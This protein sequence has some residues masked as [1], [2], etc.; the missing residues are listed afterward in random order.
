MPV[1]DNVPLMA[2]YPHPEQKMEALLKDL[3]FESVLDVGAG[4]G[5]VFHSDFWNKPEIVRK[6][7][8][9][10]FW[11]RELP[12][13]WTSLLGVDVCKLDEHYAPNSFDCVLCC[14]VLEHVA[15]SKRALEQ[16]VRVAKKAVF[17]TSA[18]ELHHIGPEQAAIEEIN[19]HQAYVKQPSVAD[20]LALGF[21][22]RVEAEQ[23][24]QL[25]AWLIKEQ[26]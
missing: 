16:L 11:I 10:I 19:K 13:G 5:G 2:Y 4:H 6:E 22:V 15:D 3:V 12:T 8:C 26:S 21:N 17:I 1:Y 14:E 7:A 9:D 23:R 24:R 25:I 18:D 20:M